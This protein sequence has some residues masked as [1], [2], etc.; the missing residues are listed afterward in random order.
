[1][2][3]AGKVR[4]DYIIALVHRQN[5]QRHAGCCVSSTLW[6]VGIINVC[7]ILVVLVYSYTKVVS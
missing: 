7:L 5:V 4:N 3:G 2:R 1:M 6:L